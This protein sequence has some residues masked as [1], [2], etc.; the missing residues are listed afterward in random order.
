MRRTSNK[1]RARMS[2]RHSKERRA[3]ALAAHEENFMS[4][5]NRDKIKAKPRRVVL[6]PVG[7]M[8]TVA[9]MGA[10]LMRR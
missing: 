6:N 8:S 5:Q 10:M 1:F 9:M 4:W 7:S 3:K 2:R